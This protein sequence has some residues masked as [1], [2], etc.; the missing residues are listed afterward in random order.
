MQDIKCDNMNDNDINVTN[1]ARK[2]KL[3]NSDQKDGN[4]SRLKMKRKRVSTTR[5]S[6]HP[7]K[8][9]KRFK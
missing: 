9:T 1:K 7:K 6:K 3:D 5:T 2:Q 8:T 4:N